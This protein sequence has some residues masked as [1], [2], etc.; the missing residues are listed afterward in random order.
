MSLVLQK[1]DSVSST[2]SIS[3]KPRRA[4]PSTASTS[5]AASAPSQLS[6]PSTRRR[7]RGDLVD[8]AAINDMSRDTKL[9]RELRFPTPPQ[10][11]ANGQLIVSGSSEGSSPRA[12]NYQGSAEERSGRRKRQKVG[13]RKGNEVDIKA[14]KPSGFAQDSD[15]ME[16]DQQVPIPRTIPN[17]GFADDD[18]EDE[19]EEEERN[20][21]NPSGD[22][23]PKPIDSIRSRIDAAVEEGNA[24]GKKI[25]TGFAGDSDE[26]EEE[27]T[28]QH[29][30]A[31]QLSTS[32]QA[33]DRNNHSR[34]N[35]DQSTRQTTGH[36]STT[37]AT[38]FAR[39]SDEED[40]GHGE[41]IEPS[42]V[43]QG[44]A[45]SDEEEA[46]EEEE[47][48]GEGGE[49]LEE[50]RSITQETVVKK[51]GVDGGDRKKEKSKSS[52]GKAASR[53]E[54]S[55]IGQNDRKRRSDSTT[56]I[57]SD[58]KTKKKR[59]QNAN[60]TL[61]KKIVQ[62]KS[63]AQDEDLPAPS[64]PAHPS[65]P[66]QRELL[67]KLKFGRISKDANAKPVAEDPP[68]TSHDNRSPSILTNSAT[69]Q[70]SN[71]RGSGN[72]KKQE[73]DP[74]NHGVQRPV[75]KD[76]Y[77]TL[78]HDML[79]MKK[80][81]EAI[82]GSEKPNWP[83]DLHQDQDRIRWWWK[84]DGNPLVNFA[85]FNRIMQGR[86]V[87]VTSPPTA[88]EIGTNKQAAAHEKD[89]LALQLV[90]SG[91]EGV[92]QADS[93]R[94]EVTAVFVHASLMSELG[95]FPGKLSELDRYRDRDDVVF[96]FYGTGLDRERALRQFWRPR[97][98]R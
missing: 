33:I 53:N 5:T 90:L 38:G 6:Q 61:E 95:R 3:K 31:R 63:L 77:I 28:A 4:P 82:C 45:G 34:D 57:T 19:E 56:S 78:N 69:D 75:S 76:G 79:K 1:E 72:T 80:L 35:V 62:K 65:V 84:I 98:F 51:K 40:S 17:R 27:G 86:K 11:D 49:Q 2:S 64:G 89:Y 39:D 13:D 54:Q 73:E 91:I 50:K 85:N 10:H 42:K 32:S 23:K 22:V 68:R 15:S 18:A 37:Q 74:F 52:G 16:E 97:K 20:R 83:I 30:P 24:S 93:P 29:A 94:P 46:E 43:N 9:L 87:F 12:G 25:V 7:Q 21:P 92:K 59:R 96:L 36:S 70:Q 55:T 81:P 66:S 44:F 47:R 26:E 48:E 14:S 58:S 41:A 8:Q 67:Q 60:D 71:S 88:R